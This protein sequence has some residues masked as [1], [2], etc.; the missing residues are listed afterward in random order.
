M[1]RRGA[2]RY[3][4]RVPPTALL[5]FY[6]NPA[7]QWVSF[8]LLFVDRTREMISTC[9]F[10]I[11]VVQ[12]TGGKAKPIDRPR[13]LSVTPRPGFGEILCVSFSV[14]AYSYG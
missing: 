8:E 10:P 4:D 5:L 11:R 3:P 9:S 7:G 14:L 2:E 1:P 12:N 13:P 6:D